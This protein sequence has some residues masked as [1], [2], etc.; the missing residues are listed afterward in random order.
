[1]V[2]PFVK[3]WQSLP[4]ASSFFPSAEEARAYHNPA[5]APVTLQLVPELVEE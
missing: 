1:M 4:A 2:D 3:Y 5:G